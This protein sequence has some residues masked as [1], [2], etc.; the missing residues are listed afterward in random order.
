[1]RYVDSKNKVLEKKLRSSSFLTE[2]KMNRN[3]INICLWLPW[4]QISQFI[5]DSCRE[6]NFEVVAWAYFCRKR[7]RSFTPQCIHL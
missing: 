5:F 1:M 3:L 4:L 2:K 7:P 6:F